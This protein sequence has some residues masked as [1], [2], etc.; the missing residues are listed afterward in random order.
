MWLFLLHFKKCKYVFQTLLA[1]KECLDEAS[2][3]EANLSKKLSA[4][5]E[6]LATL[7]DEIEEKWDKSVDEDVLLAKIGTLQDELREERRRSRNNSQ[8][9]LDQLEEER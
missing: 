9:E 4:S 8:E 7:R 5:Q 3:R 2:Q 6:M 1:L